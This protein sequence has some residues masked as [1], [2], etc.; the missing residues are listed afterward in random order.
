[1]DSEEQKLIDKEFEDLQNRI[2]QRLIDCGFDNPDSATYPFFLWAC[3]KGDWNTMISQVTNNLTKKIR[4][5]QKPVM[6]RAMRR[7]TNIK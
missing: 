4:E 2:E 1:M 6:N 7:S 5:E 3:G